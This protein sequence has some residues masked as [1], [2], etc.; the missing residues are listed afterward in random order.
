M[1]TIKKNLFK[2][3]EINNETNS[4][5][6]NTFIKKKVLLILIAQHNFFKFMVMYFKYSF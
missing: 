5:Q 4:F 6:T 2:G 3:N 1:T